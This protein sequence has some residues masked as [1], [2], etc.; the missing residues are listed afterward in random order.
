MASRLLALAATLIVAATTANAAELSI[1]IG[2]TGK[3]VAVMRRQLDAFEKASGHTV[4]VVPMPSSA[5]EQFARY[6][7]WLAAQDSSVDVYVADI[8]WAPQLATQLLDLTEPAK[9]IIGEH[10][11]SIVESQT[12]DGKLV[13]VPFTTDA[14]ALYYRKDLLKKYKAAVPKTWDELAATAATIMEKERK[15]KKGNKDLWGFVFEGKDYEGLTCNALEWIVSNGGGRIVETDGTISID[16]DKAAAAID[17]AKGWVGTI[18]PPEVLTF[19]EEEARAV[20]QQGNA[21]FMRNWPYAY[22]LGNEEGSAIAEKF[23]V[24]TLP[25]GSEG[26]KPAATL[27]GWNLAIPK[28]TRHAEAAIALVKFLASAEQQKVRALESAALPTIRA[29]YKDPEIAATQPFMPR[30]EGVFTDAVPR[31]SATT[32]LK[33]N[34]VSTSFWTAVHKTLAGDGTAAAN[35]AALK[36]QLTAIRGAAW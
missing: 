11:P 4:R 1:A 8:I 2:D 16:N 15:A 10:F 30:W 23:D 33:Y 13:A 6:K 32:R 12:I 5:T 21:L 36:G 22:A 26:G 28:Y 35:L 29:L 19:G 20:W 7:L 9:D 25:L 18:A 34:E 27:G 24:T 14:P 3:A 17:R 31:P